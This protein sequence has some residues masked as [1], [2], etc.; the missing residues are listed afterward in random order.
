MIKFDDIPDIIQEIDYS[1]PQWWKILEEGDELIVCSVFSSSGRDWGER[2]VVGDIVTVSLRDVKET[3]T[4]NKFICFE[5]NKYGI[6]FTYN[7]VKLH[8][9]K[10]KQ[11]NNELQTN[12]RAVGQ[13]GGAGGVSIPSG[14]CQ[15]AT[16]SRLIGATKSIIASPPTIKNG[17]LSP[18]QLIK[19]H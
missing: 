17:V 1:N 3:Q 16:S 7:M 13:S 18:V 10:N 11:L 9:K 4:D 6:N 14:K 2:T 8:Q 19:H 15:I 12:F 5:H